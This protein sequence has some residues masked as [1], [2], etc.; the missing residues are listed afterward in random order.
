MRFP[1]TLSIALTLT[2]LV[3][4]SQSSAMGKES[5]RLAELAARQDLCDDVCIARA[6]GRITQRE[7]VAILLQAK[8][9]LPAEEYLSFKQSL[10]RLSPPKK[11][12]QYV[13]KSKKKP[14]TP[15]SGPVIPA[16][17]T[18]PDRM[19]LPSFFR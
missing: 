19:A 5:S 1:W 7:R 8:K 10:D 12:T 6:D 2:T 3:V 14:T 11:S 17:A 13:A 9:I 4:G 15:A 16:G 18:Q